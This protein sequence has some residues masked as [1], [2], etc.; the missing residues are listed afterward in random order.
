MLRNLVSSLLQH[1]Q[2]KTTLPKAK[3]TA[4][5]AE[6]M[7]TLAKKGDLNAKQD[8]EAF[9]LDPHSILP[10]L[11]TT[12]RERY[13]DRPG[14]YTRIHKYGYREGDHA[15]HAVLELVDGPR[16][17][18]FAMTARAVGRETASSFAAE[19]PER[20]LR[21]QTKF[22]VEKVLKYRGE[23]GKE[24]FEKLAQKHANEL[25]AEPR[26]FSGLLD[27]AAETGTE[28]GTR[29]RLA[30]ERLTGMSTSATGL[31]LAKGALGRKPV[32]HVPRFWQKGWQPKSGLPAPV[33]P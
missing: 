5:L 9:L 19:Q 30:G 33:A 29:K 17:L 12:Y 15:P 23:E 27:R 7:I 8:A 2:I 18:K 4:R 1:E 14:G 22:A 28:N 13:M 25:L 6:K 16:D 21:E 11:F 31:R 3:E 10:K 24:A 26:A 20:N 32:P